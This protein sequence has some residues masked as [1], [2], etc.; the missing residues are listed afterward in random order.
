MIQTF[1]LTSFGT[2]FLSC[3]MH[4]IHGFFKLQMDSVWGHGDALVDAGRASE[5]LWKELQVTVLTSCC[6]L[7]KVASSC[8]SESHSI[9]SPCPFQ[10][11]WKSSSHGQ[12]KFHYINV[13]KR[14]PI[15]GPE[16]ALTLPLFLWYILFILPNPNIL[17]VSTLKMGGHLFF[18]FFLAYFQHEKL[19]W[20]IHLNKLLKKVCFMHLVSSFNKWR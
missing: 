17:Q 6:N 12:A 13:Q 2:H 16:T 15:L 1:C 14:W 19:T 11:L 20:R 7:E 5:E 3:G 4:G 10:N 18:S 8:C 9:G